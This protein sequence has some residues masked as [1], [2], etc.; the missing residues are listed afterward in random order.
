MISVRWVLV[1]SFSVAHW[2]LCSLDF[3]RGRARSGSGLIFSQ[4]LVST[5]ETCGADAPGTSFSSS[6][7]SSS[8][9]EVFRSQ[10]GIVPKV[11]A[12][13]GSAGRCRS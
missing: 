12:R 10:T 6:E 3:L 2:S 1:C 13:T 11:E 7:E 4:S 8:K 5:L 9:Y